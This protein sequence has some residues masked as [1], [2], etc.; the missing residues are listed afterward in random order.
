M[1]STTTIIIF[2]GILLFAK[3]SFAQSNYC[4]SNDDGTFDAYSFGKSSAKTIENWVSKYEKSDYRSLLAFKEAQYSLGF[5]YLEKETLERKYCENL[6]GIGKSWKDLFKRGSGVPA[7]NLSQNELRILDEN[8]IKSV[9]F[10]DRK[11]DDFPNTIRAAKDGAIPY[12]ASVIKKNEELGKVEKKYRSGVELIE[13]ISTEYI[14]ESADWE[15]LLYLNLKGRDLWNEIIDLSRERSTHS[16]EE[17][18]RFHYFNDQRYVKDSQ[19]NQKIISKIVDY[20]REVFSYLGSTELKVNYGLSKIS[21]FDPFFVQ[22]IQEIFTSSFL[23]FKNDIHRIKNNSFELESVLIEK[24]IFPIGEISKSYIDVSILNE[25]KNRFSYKSNLIPLLSMI[26]AIPNCEHMGLRPEV[27]RT[28]I[29]GFDHERYHTFTSAQFGALIFNNQKNC[30]DVNYI[31][32]KTGHNALYSTESK[33]FDK[34]V[35]KYRD[36]SVLE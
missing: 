36:L 4:H 22:V 24:N 11:R 14:E 2:T 10:F 3:F 6:F 9:Q 15:S 16:P 25:Q 23:F 7:K 33:I 20:K 30:G 29:Q 18:A 19:K 28:I 31:T 21:S 35:E 34:L 13:K 26:M 27:F 12:D 5:Y 32:S 17:E 1:K 8:E